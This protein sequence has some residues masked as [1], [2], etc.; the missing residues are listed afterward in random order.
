[1]SQTE[2]SPA[3][4]R[5]EVESLRARVEELQQSQIQAR[6]VEEGLRSIVQ[7]ISSAR[8][9]DFF[10]ALV[11]HLAR[12]FGASHAFV[13]ELVGDA[14]DRIRTLAFW[15]KDEFVENF[16]YRLEMVLNSLVMEFDL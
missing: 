9:D 8:G 11:R 3:E 1:M 6:R 4:L 12:V 10:R 7:G 5:A 13:G 2:P 16:E 14:K 15:A